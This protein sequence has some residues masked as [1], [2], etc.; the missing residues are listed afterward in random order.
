MA[1][2]TAVVAFLAVGLGGCSRDRDAPPPPPPSEASPVAA[3]TPPTD[4]PL[5]WYRAA[6]EVPE[7]DVVFFLGLPGPGGRELVYQ[8]GADRNTA[9]A[10]VGADGTVRGELPLLQ[11]DLVL[12]PPDGVGVRRGRAVTAS[13]AF[14][15]ATLALVATPVEGPDPAALASA[16][17]G[18][19]A[20]PSF[21]ASTTYWRV[22]F[23]ESGVARLALEQ[24]APGSFVALLDL[25]S[26]NY[27]ILAGTGDGDRLV[28][29]GFDG[30]SPYR[31]RLTFDRARRAATGDWLA[32]AQ[33]GWRERVRAERAAARFE[34]ASTQP[35]PIGAVLRL[36]EVAA[37]AGRPAVIEL[38]GSWCVA[39]KHAAAVLRGLHGEL[40]PQGL[41]FLTLLY[42]FTDDADAAR[43]QAARFQDA[44]RIPWSVV[45]VP[46]TPEEIGELL[47]PEL[48][49]LDPSGFPIALFVD[50]T[51][52]VVASHVSFPAPATGAAYAEA[53]AAY[54]R[55][56]EALLS[57][58]APAR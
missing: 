52:R 30:S 53:V 2:R 20:A 23:A 29:G 54:R 10:T 38:A 48:G 40:H 47:P 44:Y 14:G 1:A 3:P 35:R 8:T 6:L 37:V 49:G 58:S 17:P 34:V 24:V 21:D 56:A 19:G 45:A 33:L 50:R 57:P 15:A 18:A 41:Q 43:V 25:P 28:L 4:A 7:D 16:P 55:H 32:G 36:P 26:Q 51:G 11:S 42:E 13:R 46:G 22:A 9:T 12:G 39:C 27:A 31:L 5:T